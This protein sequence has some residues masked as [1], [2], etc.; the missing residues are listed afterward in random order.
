MQEMILLRGARQLL[1]LRGPA[2]PR[3]GPALKDLAI[4]RDGALLI[5]DGVIVDVGPTRR[6]ENLAAARKAREWDVTGRV[7]MPGFCDSHAHLCGALN[8]RTIPSKRMESQ[9]RATAAAC[10]RHGTTAI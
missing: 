4:I 7:V 6:V 9:S 2:G 1:T 8:V 10:L 5:R 3:R